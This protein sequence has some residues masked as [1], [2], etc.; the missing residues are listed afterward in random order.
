M[1]KAATALIT[2]VVVAAACSPAPDPSGV[3]AKIDRS[4]EIRRAAVEQHARQF[5]EELPVREAGSQEE[6]AAASYITGHLQ[7]AGYTVS[8][9]DVPLGNLVE[10]SNI[11]AL[12][13]SGDE[14]QAVVVVAYDSDRGSR[15]GTAIGL[16]LEAARALSFRLPEHDVSFVALGAQSTGPR[17]AMGLAEL[18]SSLRAQD[19][20]PDLALIAS[21]RGAPQLRYLGMELPPETKNVR[22]KLMSFLMERGG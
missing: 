5:D 14:P 7:L 19:V 4:P 21:A 11:I 18:E 22:A 12:P 15:E 20:E 1:K 8:F 9:D 13:P 16:F 6:L 3:A 10:S 2:L 17:P